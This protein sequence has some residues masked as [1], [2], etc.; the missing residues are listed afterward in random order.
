MYPLE[1][2]GRLPVGYAT[3][4]TLCLAERIA[5]YTMLAELKNNGVVKTWEIVITFLVSAIP[6]GLY[7]TIFFFSPAVIASL[8]C[9][10]GAYT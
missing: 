1:R 2:L 10:T 5:G 7:F 6:S 9:L 4:L 3:S 8:G